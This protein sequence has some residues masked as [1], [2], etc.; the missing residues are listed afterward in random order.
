MHMCRRRLQSLAIAIERKNH[1]P[2]ATRSRVPL[3]HAASRS[4]FTP[5]TPTRR[6]PGV[7]GPLRSPGVIKRAAERSAHSETASL[8]HALMEALLQ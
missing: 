3:V 6:G 1:A 8:L 2:G 4:G 7:G 5:R